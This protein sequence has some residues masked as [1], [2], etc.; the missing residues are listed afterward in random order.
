[1]DFPLKASKIYSSKFKKW[2]YI[3]CINKFQSILKVC[4]KNLYINDK[5][6]EK[7]YFKARTEVCF[8]IIETPFYFNGNLM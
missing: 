6:K 1:M 8:Q 7:F 3:R 5:A 2:I 4:F